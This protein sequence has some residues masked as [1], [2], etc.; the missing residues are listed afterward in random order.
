MKYKIYYKRFSPHIRCLDD[1]ADH[2]ITDFDQHEIDT[3]LLFNNAEV[4]EIT[5]DLKSADIL[6]T[7]LLFWEEIIDNFHE[8]PFEFKPGLEDRFQK[9][10]QD[11]NLILVFNDYIFHHQEGYPD[12]R[13]PNVIDLCKRCNLPFKDYLGVHMNSEIDVSRYKKHFNVTERN[14]CHSDYM[15]N[16]SHAVHFDHDLMIDLFKQ[17]ENFHCTHWW[18]SELEFDTIKYGLTPDNQIINWDLAYDCWSKFYFDHPDHD[19]DINAKFYV[20]PNN[21]TYYAGPLNTD[22]MTYDTCLHNHHNRGFLRHKLCD[23]LSKYPG[24]IGNPARGVPLVTNRPLTDHVVLGIDGSGYAPPH[25]A[26]Y[27]VTSISFYVESMVF[28]NEEDY[29]PDDANVNVGHLATEKT[30]LPIAKGHFILPFSTP[31][32]YEYLQTRYDIRFPDFIDISFDNIPDQIERFDAYLKEVK[33][34][35]DMGGRK[36]YE[37][38]ERHIDLLIYNRNKLA[39]GYKQE[40]A[41]YFLNRDKQ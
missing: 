23:L 1:T 19:P 8:S 11:T 38:K 15:F 7:Q 22:D 9:I 18:G 29:S 35:C 10:F 31:G 21:L 2:S 6:V 4:F 25:N 37:L 13:L 5:K 20:S 36:L 32:F 12:T 34:I 24:Y 16:R 40:L 39:E 17:R 14:F 28:N 3:M 27:N 30:W 26:Y 41:E 33:R